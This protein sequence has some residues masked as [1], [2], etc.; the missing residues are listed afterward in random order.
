MAT[1]FGRKQTGDTL[2]FRCSE[3]ASLRLCACLIILCGFSLFFFGQGDAYPNVGAAF[4]YEN[5]SSRIHPMTAQ[6]PRME[7]P[8]AGPLESGLWIDDWDMPPLPSD[9][10]ASENLQQSAAIT[11]SHEWGRAIAAGVLSLSAALGLMSVFG[12]RFHWL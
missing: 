4:H 1:V 10:L 8:V 7:K 9:L 5:V 3:I 6:L 11:P 12:H 2:F